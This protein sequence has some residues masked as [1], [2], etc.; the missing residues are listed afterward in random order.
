MK[1]EEKKT[2]NKLSY[3][4]LENTAHQLSEQ[5]RQLFNENK[6]LSAALE[7]ANSINFFKK[8]EYLWMVITKDSEYLPIEFKIK[9]G[10]EFM[11]LMTPEQEETK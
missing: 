5:C 1:M 8:L 2:Q 7:Q 4:E 9:C 3:E 10:E 11:T 6:K